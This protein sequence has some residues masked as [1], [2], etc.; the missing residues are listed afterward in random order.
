MTF[1]SWNLARVRFD[2]DLDPEPDNDQ[3]RV[4]VFVNDPWLE[5]QQAEREIWWWILGIGG[6]GAG[7][8]VTA[9]WLKR[10]LS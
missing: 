3:I 5:K 8:F 1:Y 10:R 6:G 4:R 7:V 9:F 2:N